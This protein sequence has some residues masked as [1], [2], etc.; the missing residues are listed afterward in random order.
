[1]EQ[2]LKFVELVEI[3]NAGLDRTT[4]EKLAPLPYDYM[5][6]LDLAYLVVVLG[7]IHLPV[8][9]TAVDRCNSTVDPVD[10]VGHLTS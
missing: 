3:Q 2:T 5:Q 4:F 10:Q 9:D 1:M 8:P 7:Y 6:M